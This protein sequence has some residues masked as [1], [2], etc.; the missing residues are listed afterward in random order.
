MY[1]EFFVVSMRT[2]SLIHEFTINLAVWNECLNWIGDI[3]A[4]LCKPKQ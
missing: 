2:L 3:S 1:F 4:M